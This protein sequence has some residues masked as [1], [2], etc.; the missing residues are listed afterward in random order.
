MAPLVPM[1]DFEMEERVREYVQRYVREGERFSI[2]YVPRDAPEDIVARVIREVRGT[3]VIVR[4][5]GE[6]P[7]FVFVKVEGKRPPPRYYFTNEL[8]YPP[9]HYEEF[10][11]ALLESYEK[12]YGD[13]DQG[14]LL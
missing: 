1:P 2:V 14:G 12:G 3:P 8:F 6:N 13:G 7:V 5:M 11:N 9:G 4:E 10:I